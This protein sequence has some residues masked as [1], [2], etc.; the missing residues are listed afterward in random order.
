VIRPKREKC[1]AVNKAERNWKPTKHFNIR[2][3]DT[4]FGVCS[5]S[6][7][8]CFY[9]VFSY[10][11]TSP[12]ICKVSVYPVPLYIE[13]MSSVFCLFLS[14]IYFC[15]LFCFVVFFV[16]AGN[17]WLCIYLFIYLFIYLLTY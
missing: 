15:F 1:V 6:F 17:F 8:T 12:P 10:Y 2:H 7:Q 13:I 3:G 14:F 16:V 11:A 9:L 5:H 4:E